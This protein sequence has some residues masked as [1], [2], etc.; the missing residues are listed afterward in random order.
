[1]T[2][3]IVKLLTSYEAILLALVLNV[4]GKLLKEFPPYANRYI[5]HALCL[6]GALSY[7]LLRHAWTVENI[8]LGFLVG[9]GAV[10]LHQLVKQHLDS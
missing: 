7:P 5:P 4:L 10:G 3:E 1:M 9:A 6:A 2:D 8:L